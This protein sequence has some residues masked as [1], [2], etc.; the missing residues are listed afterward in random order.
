MLRVAQGLLVD[1]AG[2][3]LLGRRAATKAMFPGRWDAIGGRAQPHETDTAALIREI[4]EELAVTPTDLS[5]LSY[6]LRPSPAGAYWRAL[7]VV[8]RWSGGAPRNAS[9]EHDALAWFTPTDV[10][11][12]EPLA[13]LAYGDL[14]RLATRLAAR[15]T[16]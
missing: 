2:R 9:D 5:L 7:F 8:T 4:G 15:L 1:G 6:G 11:R 10:D 12:L 14:S 3:V 13:D 16:P